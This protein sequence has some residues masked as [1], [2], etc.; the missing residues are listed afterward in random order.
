V[1]ASFFSLFDSRVYVQYIINLYSFVSRR[2]LEMRKRFFL[3]VL[4]TLAVL[5]L[6]GGAAL[7]DVIFEPHDPTITSA[8]NFSCEAGTGD[9]FQVKSF[10]TPPIQYFA[11]D[12]PAD[13]NVDI[14]TGVLTIS[15]TVPA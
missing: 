12:A 9:S 15:A 8:N 5:M 6:T 11:D 3:R 2:V 1:R 10:G 7:A 14:S 13:V 4:T